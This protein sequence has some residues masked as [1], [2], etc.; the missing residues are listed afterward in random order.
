MCTT[1]LKKFSNSLR[2]LVAYTSKIVS[3]GFPW[4]RNVKHNICFMIEKINLDNL[5]PEPETGGTF[6]PA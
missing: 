2:D 6:C 5:N 1:V 3:N 4:Q